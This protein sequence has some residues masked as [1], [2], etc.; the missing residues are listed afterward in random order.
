MDSETKTLISLLNSNFSKELMKA[1]IRHVARDPNLADFTRK[2]GNYVF[3]YPE[4][5]SYRHEQAWK[6]YSISIAAAEP[7]TE[8]LAMAYGNRSALLIH[9]LKY[10]ASMADIDRALEITK[11]G[12]P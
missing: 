10:Q 7:S 11:N 1:E 12:C 4:H 2:D 8:G 9:L 6:K 5:N 3:T